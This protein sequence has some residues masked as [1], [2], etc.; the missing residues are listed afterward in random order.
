MF[1]SIN[2]W[3]PSTAA[4]TTT[5]ATHQSWTRTEL[6]STSIHT[7][8]AYV[9]K[10]VYST[11]ARVA[12]WCLSM[13]RLVM[14]RINWPSH[15]T[16]AIYEYNVDGKWARYISERQIV[17]EDI[18]CK[19]TMIIIVEYQ[20]NGNHSPFMPSRFFIGHSH[21]CL[22]VVISFGFYTAQHAQFTLHLILIRCNSLCS[23]DLIL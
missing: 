18:F 4:T 19:F 17:I 11:R 16:Y 6:T 10:T 22:Y 7:H 23:L 8:F 3:F 1:S 21:L 14:H 13:Y 15:S 5:T 20:N 12:V 2:I 9:G